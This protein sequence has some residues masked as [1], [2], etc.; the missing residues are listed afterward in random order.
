VKAST[1]LTHRVIS[2]VLTGALS[3]LAF[4]FGSEGWAIVGAV[5]LGAAIVDVMLLIA[6]A[7]FRWRHQDRRA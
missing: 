3:A 7:W 1:A 6:V 4:S 5:L 2:L